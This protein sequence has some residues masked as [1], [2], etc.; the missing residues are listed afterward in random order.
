MFISTCTASTWILIH[1]FP[2]NLSLT[3]DEVERALRGARVVFCSLI[4][5]FLQVSQMHHRGQN[6]VKFPS[7][8]IQMNE[9]QSWLLTTPSRNIFTTSP[10][11]PQ[12]QW[13]RQ[14]ITHI[15]IRFMFESALELMSETKVGNFE[16]KGSGGKAAGPPAPIKVGN[17]F[18]Y[19]SPI[20]THTPIYTHSYLHP[21]I[22]PA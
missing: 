14:R 17:R 19:Y 22:H 20:Y 6:P 15:P 21:H 8:L 12:V 13:V 11:V 3:P 10:L 16:M 18:H 1:P 7:I 4:V 5:D 2:P 9:V